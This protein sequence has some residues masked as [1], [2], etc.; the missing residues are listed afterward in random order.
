MNAA[1]PASENGYLL[2]LDLGG[3]R[4]KAL[5]ITPGGVELT[6]E[7]SPSGG[8][9]WQDALRG[10][11]ARITARHGKPLAIGAAAPGLAAADGRSIEFMPGRLQGLVGLDWAELLESAPPVP[12]INDAHAAL[13]GEVWMGAAKSERDVVLLTLGTGVGGAILSDGRLLRGSIG[14]AGHLGHITLDPAGPPDIANTPGSLEDAVGNHSL[15]ARSH[16]RYTTTAALVAD[17]A[18]GDAEAEKIWAR[19]IRDLAAAIASLVNVLDP[20]LVLIGGGISEAGERLFSP[21]ARELDRFEWRPGGH[22]VRIARAQLG[23]WAG[24]YGAATRAM[25][26][27]QS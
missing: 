14:R 1:S 27:I 19:M 9:S 6:R 5:A 17:A 3:T 10:C 13:L 8:D 4:L 15:A 18:L 20:A 2:G 26:Q 16:G 7:T 12:V 23:D 11:V 24:A 22:R 25:C 21:L